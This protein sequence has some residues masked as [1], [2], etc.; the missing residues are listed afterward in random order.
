[1]LAEN[2]KEKE[3]MGPQVSGGDIIV[4]FPGGLEIGSWR[5]IDMM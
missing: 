1:M 2:R 5:K 3:G 4:S